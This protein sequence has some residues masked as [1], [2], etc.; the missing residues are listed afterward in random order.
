MGGFVGVDGGVREA[1]GNWYKSVRQEE[2]SQKFVSQ[3]GVGIWFVFHVTF[4]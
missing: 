4:A 1:R 3:P 2:D